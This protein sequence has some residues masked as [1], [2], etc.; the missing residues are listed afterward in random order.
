VHATRCAASTSAAAAPLGLS[1]E[2]SQVRSNCL[3]VEQSLVSRV[4]KVFDCKRGLSSEVSQVRSNCLRVEQSLVSR[5]PKVFDCKRGREGGREKGRKGE[6]EK[7][8]A[9]EGGRATRG[10][11]ARTVS[12]RVARGVARPR[13]WREATGSASRHGDGAVASR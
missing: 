6:R 2:V 10:G 12:A 3:R 11:A 5:V 8:S 1:S 7:G 9:R 13:W 4:P